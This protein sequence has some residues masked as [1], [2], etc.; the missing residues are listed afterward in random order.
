MWTIT[1]ITWIFPSHLDKRDLCVIAVVAVRCHLCEH[2][3]HLLLQPVHPGVDVLALLLRLLHLRPHLLGQLC[4]QP[5]PLLHLFALRLQSFAL[6]LLPPLQLGHRAVEGLQFGAHVS[7]LGF[8]L[9][10]VLLQTLAQLQEAVSHH[11]HVVPGGVFVP[12]RQGSPVGGEAGC[13][14]HQNGQ[15]EDEELWHLHLC[16][17]W[18]SVSIWKLVLSSLSASVVCSWMAL[19]G[20]Y[21]SVLQQGAP[22]IGCWGLEGWL[23]A[24]KVFHSGHPSEDL[25]H[26]AMK[27]P[28][29]WLN[30]HSCGDVKW[31]LFYFLSNIFLQ[32]CIWLF[33][34]LC[35]L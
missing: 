6:L 23:G 22:L 18:E 19:W 11:V 1:E 3:I 16:V 7:H 8:G 31:I 4:R 32:V 26:D 2:L 35:S 13:C 12:A 25:S 10:H 9:V 14:V 28:N 34:Q 30:T 15:Q 20:F 5:L 33:F 29:Y 17:C 27:G 24:W 21:S